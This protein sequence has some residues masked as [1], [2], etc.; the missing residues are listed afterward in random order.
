MSALSHANTQSYEHQV[1]LVII[2]IIIIIMIIINFIYVSGYLNYKL[3]GDTTKTI[4][5]IKCF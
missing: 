5:E 1:I 3:I 4:T 2:I